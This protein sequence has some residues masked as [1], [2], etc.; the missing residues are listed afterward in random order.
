MNDLITKQDDISK[1]VSSAVDEAKSFVINSN[2]DYLA[3]DAHCAGL[4]KLKNKIVAN[5]KE[6]KAAAKAA[7]KAIC[8]QEAGHL[9]GIDEARLIYRKNLDSWDKKQEEVRRAEEARL[10]AIARKQAEERALAEAVLAESSGDKEG[11]T[12]ILEAPVEYAP[13]I[14]QKQ[15]PKTQTVLQT[16]WKFRVVNA[17]LIPREYLAVDDVKIGQVVRALKDATNIAGIQAY[18]ERK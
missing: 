3:A 8:D 15:T 17:A 14:L 10:Q 5:F 7:H 1:E 16:R 11:A 6:S 18:S 2:N 4:L 13:V 12:A 9:E